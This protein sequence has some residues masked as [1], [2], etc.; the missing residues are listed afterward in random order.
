MALT[1]KKVQQDIDDAKSRSMVGNVNYLKAGKPVRLR[2]V[3][4]EDEDGSTI[5]S[6]PLVEWNRQTSAKSKPILDRGTMFRAPDAIEQINKLASDN[7]EE[8]PYR[9]R[10]RYLVNAIDIDAKPPVMAVWAL[11][12]TV[13]QEIADMAISDEW[14]DVL[15][16]KDGH[17]F[18]ISRTGTGLDTVYTCT[19]LR[20]PWKVPK[21][22]QKQIRDPLSMVVD[23]GL[24]K[25]CRL[26]G[27]DLE[28]LFEDPD[29]LEMVEPVETT[30][31]ITEGLDED[32]D[33]EEDEDVDDE[34]EED[35]EYEED[36]EDEE[37]DDEE[38]DLDEDDEEDEDDDEA[39][40]DEE[41]EDDEEDDDEEE[42][43]KKPVKKKTP[44]KKK[45][46]KKTPAKK[47]KPGKK[48]ESTD[49]VVAG[50][51]SRSKKKKKR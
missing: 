12:T 5:F 2:I 39:E 19:V 8:A 51:L 36:S 38:D 29:S 20:K 37:D 7:G 9:R 26:V 44:A 1:K 42:E 46:A 23:I 25:Q 3:E 4:F 6:R 45:A 34:E 49:S 22:L 41:D 48:D 17:A 11:P 21:D 14:V 13:W 32:E 24:E 15:E 27:V 50:I 47:K 30:G 31:P 18:R 33:E 40:E 35:E 16:F 10:T 28:D 43:E